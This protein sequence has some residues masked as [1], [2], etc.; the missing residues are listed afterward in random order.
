[1]NQNIKALIADDDVVNLKLITIYLKKLGVIVEGAKDGLELLGKYLN[2][3][4]R[5]DII[6]ID[7][8]M[9]IMN[10]IQ[11]T[12][13]ILDFEKEKNIP[14]TPIIA[15]TTNIFESKIIKIVDDYIL[16]PLNQTSFEKIIKKY[17]KN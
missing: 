8:N 17:I 11:T 6:F 7:I 9:P 4:N 15:V 12:L 2:N 16:K 13:E 1:M 14:H 10:G 3:P 5:Y